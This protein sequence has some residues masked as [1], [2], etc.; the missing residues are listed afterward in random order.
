M[1]SAVIFDL[2]GVLVDTVD[3]HY[4][5]WC[6]VA[7]RLGVPFSRSDND[8]LRGIRRADA[9]RIISR[10]KTIL[11]IEAQELLELK[12][13]V[14]R[15]RIHVLGS[16]VRIPYAGEV[17][18]MVHGLGARVAVASASRHAELLVKYAQIQSELDLVSGGEF[19]PAKPDPSQLLYIASQLC[20]SMQNCVVVEDSI[21]GLTAARAAGMRSV[22]VGP[23]TGV[24]T[25]AEYHIPAL[26]PDALM[27]ALDVLAIEVNP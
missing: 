16:R 3:A 2:D 27:R 19:T 11:D 18:A 6:V 25:A 4:E 26:T 12:A 10:G 15:R 22:G 1:I 20:V 5:A 23:S 17:L 7:T 24:M 13:E 21:A 14:Y 8:R 9:L